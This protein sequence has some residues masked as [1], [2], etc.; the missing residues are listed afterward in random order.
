MTATFNLGKFTVKEDSNGNLIITHDTN[1]QILAY[2][3]GTDAFITTKNLLADGE[4]FD[5]QNISDFSNLNSLSTDDATVNNKITWPGGASLSGD[6]LNWEED[7]NSPFTASN[8][9]SKQFTLA[10]DKDMVVLIPARQNIGHKGLQVNGD[11]GSNYDKVDNNDTVNTGSDRWTFPSFPRSYTRI[12]LIANF[13]RGAIG[14]NAEPAFAQSGDT[15]YGS[16][17]NVR[18]PINSFTVIDSSS[19]SVTYEAYGVNIG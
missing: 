9:T 19:R 2:D 4:D 3:E 17:G 11:S 1:G 6:P 8:T 7:P 5:G 12:T 16:N 15:V 14:M 18:P 10:N 13:S